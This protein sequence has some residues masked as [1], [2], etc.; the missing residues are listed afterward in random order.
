MG[1]ISLTLAFGLDRVTFFSQLQ[2]GRSASSNPRPLMASYILFIF[3]ASAI[4]LGRIFSRYF[5][6]LH[7]EPKNET[8]GA[9]LSQLD[10]QLEAKTPNEPADIWAK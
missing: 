3:G 1:Y 10:P 4:A 5:L 6:S 2:M 8:R 9:Y 7:P